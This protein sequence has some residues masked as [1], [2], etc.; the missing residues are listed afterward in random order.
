MAITPRT[1]PTLTSELLA[2]DAA[3]TARIDQLLYP[4]PRY[5]RHTRAILNAQTALRSVLS[6]RE[7]RCYLDLE[8]VVNARF[9]YTSSLVV[10]WAFEQGRLHATTPQP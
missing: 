7:W 4:D 6:D 1:T 8:G 10:R 9:L 3:V 5:R 2:D